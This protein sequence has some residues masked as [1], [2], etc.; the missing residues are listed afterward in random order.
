MQT[1][2]EAPHSSMETAWIHFHIALQS[3][4]AWK[5]SKGVIVPLPQIDSVPESQHAELFLYLRNSFKRKE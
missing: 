4:Y 5:V 3:A 2:W 1:A